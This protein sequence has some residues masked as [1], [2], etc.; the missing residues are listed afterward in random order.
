MRLF[1]FEVPDGYTSTTQ[2]RH[3]VTEQEMLEFMRVIAEANDGVFPDQI[4]DVPSELHNKFI[5]MPK[6]ERSPAGQKLI[7]M[8]DYYEKIQLRGYPLREFLLENADWLSF[9]YIG[10]GAKLG[11]KDTV[12]AWYRLKNAKNP[13]AYR[14]VYGDLSVRDVA[15]GDLPLPVER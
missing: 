9:R 12:I 10:K 5:E 14:E 4:A 3:I 6:A 2:K 1:R 7:E 8:V 13:D 11:D 15:R